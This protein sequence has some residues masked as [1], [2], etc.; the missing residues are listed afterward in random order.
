MGWTMPA[1]LRVSIADRPGALAT[2]TAALAGAGANVLAVTVLEHEQGRA[3]DDLLL[4]WPYER[5]WDDLERA[6]ASCAGARVH[7]RRH[8]RQPAL[9]HDTDLFGQML[10]Q[11]ERA[12]ETVVDGLPHLLLADWCAAFDRR[13][14]RE[15]IYQTPGSPLPLP[16]TSGPLD[17]SRAVSSGEEMLVLAQLPDSSLRVI[18]GRYQGPGFTRS[19]VDRCVALLG[20]AAGAVRLGFRPAA[21]AEPAAVTARL[22]TPSENPGTVAD[23]T[24]S[25]ATETMPG[26]VS[27]V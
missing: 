5:P 16:E 11:P 1:H 10:Q 25:V 20:V 8:V 23:R 15:S 24:E 19:E 12:V 13:H 17:R 7:G 26:P 3:I 6:V 4:D 18:V 2:L 14:P 9:T 21:R 22:L 27:R